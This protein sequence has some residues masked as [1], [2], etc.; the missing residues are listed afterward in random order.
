M[1]APCSDRRELQLKQSDSRQNCRHD[2][3]SEQAALRESRLE[4]S[5]LRE[6][7]RELFEHAPVA[8]LSV[9]H[10]TT[11]IDANVAA[12]ELL[13][14][15]R[16]ALIGRTFASFVDAP[17]IELFTGQMRA[18]STSRVAQRGDLLLVLADSSRRDV[19]L[20]SIRDHLDPQRCRLALVDVTPVR[21]LQRQLERSHRLEAIGTFSS[22]VAHDFS[23][24]LAVVAAG[25]DV[26]LE[27]I[28][29]PELASK[30]LQ[31]IKRASLQGRRMVRQ[32]LRFASGPEC[33][34][35]AVFELDCA[36]AGAEGA[37]RQ[38]LGTAVQLRVRL[39]A[40]GATVALDLGGPEEVL[41][42]LASNAVHAMPDGGALTIET[43]VV[44]ANIG[45]DPR[46]PPQAY[47]VLS[48][49]DTGRGMD[50]RTQARAFEPFFTTKS[51]GN[52][53]GLGLSM[54]YGIVKRAGGHIQLTSELTMG[55]T[56][57]IYLPLTGG[58]AALSGLAG[59]DANA[60][61]LQTEQ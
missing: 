34:S 13:Q 19:R 58:A 1:K 22:G 16:A 11:I 24:L 43:N 23:N 53:T 31:R 14:V 4:V 18:T 3:R 56:F 59:S 10:A 49:S 54:V 9:D 5:I 37:L 44:A 2:S 27:L 38:L 25:A 15:E 51:A 41:L 55:T 46:L 21:Q 20:E 17:S 57:R 29:T 42:N 60:A 45:L 50:V 47:A 39:N 36:V 8:Y 7:Y 28:D 52:G 26:A 33:D 61:A 12:S 30:P 35:M 48:V 6:R 40:P 32:L